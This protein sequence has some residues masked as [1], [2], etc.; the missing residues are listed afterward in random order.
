MTRCLRLIFALSLV[1]IPATLAQ[2][3]ILLANF[4]Y[5]GILSTRGESPQIRPLLSYG[6]PSE[7]NAVGHI[8]AD[9]TLLNFFNG[10]PVELAG[11]FSGFTALA[12]DGLDEQVFVGFEF[13][14]MSS[15]WSLEDE[16]TVLAWAFSLAPNVGNPDFA[17]YE[18]TRIE[19]LGT[20]YITLPDDEIELTFEYS[21]YGNVPE[22]GTLV[23]LSLGGVGLLAGYRSRRRR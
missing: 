16:S 8:W 11:D 4:P 2:A 9:M 19:V 12:T 20:S 21:V 14:G 6:D 13:V 7:P 1:L 23:M 18:I 3:E 17:G 15:V 10:V 22:P 5:T